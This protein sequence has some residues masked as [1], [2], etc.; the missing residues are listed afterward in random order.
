MSPDKEK[1]A[2]ATPKKAVAKPKKAASKEAAP[3]KATKA[4]ASSS[5]TVA[6][7]K[8]AA[9]KASAP[10][11][12]AAVASA[13]SAGVP[14][15]ASVPSARREPTH[16]EISYRAYFVYIERGGDHGLHENDWFLAE[17]ELRELFYKL[18]D[19]FC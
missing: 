16:A 19:I 9:K 4:A 17:K 12:T 11:V 18:V 10:K 1:K 3:E 13:V 14:E 6:P 2:A 8:T 7:K 5:S 15:V